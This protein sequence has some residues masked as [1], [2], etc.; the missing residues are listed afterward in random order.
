MELLLIAIYVA[1]CMGVFKLFKIP[2]NQWSLSTAAL[3][4]MIG[5]FLLI[6]GMAYNHPYTTNARIYYAVT[7]IFPTV[8]GRVI[9]VPVESNTPLKAGDILFRIDPRPYEATLR[10]A[11]ANALRDQAARDQARSQ[12]K[13]YQEL[14]QKN[15]VSKEAYAQFRTNA[16]TAEATADLHA[17]AHR[18]SRLV[19]G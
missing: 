10:Q 7:P 14:L 16:E 8:K 13:R 4:G 1:L 6:L 3:I 5:I 19:F 9:E 18:E 12:E 2:V 15:F 17:M 11:E